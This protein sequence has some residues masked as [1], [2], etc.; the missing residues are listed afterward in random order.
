KRGGAP[1]DPDAGVVTRDEIGIDLNSTVRSPADESLSL[2]ETDLALAPQQGAARRRPEGGG[3]DLLHFLCREGVPE[4]VHGAH[5]PWPPRAI[6]KS[7]TN[8][9]HEAGQARIR[10]E[11]PR[12]D[13]IVQLRPGDRPGARVE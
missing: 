5:E 10:D 1:R 9:G 7:V 11:C 12:P 8:L 4:P 2:D 13:E 6:G 3:E